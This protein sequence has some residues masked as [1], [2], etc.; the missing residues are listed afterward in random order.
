MVGGDHGAPGTSRRKEGRKRGRRGEEAVGRK[1]TS[2]PV[3]EDRRLLHMGEKK[4]K[5]ER[6][7]K[8]KKTEKMP[9]FLSVSESFR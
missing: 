1:S 3:I 8:E 7:K 5:I 6:E 2:R 9:K 4:K